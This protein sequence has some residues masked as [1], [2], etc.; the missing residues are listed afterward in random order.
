MLTCLGL[1]S[2]RTVRSDMRSSYL[3]IE[4][5]TE[6]PS[7]ADID[8]VYLDGIYAYGDY[9][10]SVD[11]RLKLVPPHNFGPPERCYYNVVTDHPGYTLNNSGEGRALYIP[12]TPGQ[13]FYQQ[14]HTNTSVWIGDLL[15]HVLG[16]GPVGGNLSPM[17][18][19]TRFDQV[20]RGSELVHLVNASGHYGNSY[21]AP[22]R[23]TG[24][25]V[26]LP[27]EQLPR[28]VHSL[29]TDTDYDASLA[30]GILTIDVPEL[31]LFDAIKVVWPDETT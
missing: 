28:S 30:D 6:L 12:W 15:Q 23:M 16:L 25:R 21:F 19:V 13:L 24:L 4:D 2:V 31:G 3:L 20:G 8:L 22:V 27:A 10:A 9:A 26:E 5:K 17:V 29:V 18:E 11:Q 1:E 14:G 7:M